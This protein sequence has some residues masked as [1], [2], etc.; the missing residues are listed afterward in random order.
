MTMGTLVT[1]FGL[2]QLF[3]GLI[4]LHSQS[5]YLFQRRNSE[6]LYEMLLESFQCKYLPRVNFIYHFEEAKLSL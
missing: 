3:S 6:L 5:Q 2:L 1:L 4:C